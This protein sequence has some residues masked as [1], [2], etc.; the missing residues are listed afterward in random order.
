MKANKFFMTAASIMMSALVATSF[1]ACSEDEDPL[2]DIDNDKVAE[3]VDFSNLT[4]T[5]TEEGKIII[6]GELKTNTKL[7]TFTLV[8]TT[9]L[10]EKGN[11]IEY[12]LLENV[13]DNNRSE[14]DRSDWICKIPATTVP[15]D[16]YRLDV[17]ARMGKT[18]SAQIGEEFSFK[19]ATGD[20]KSVG[21][22]LSF[23]KLKSYM[24]DELKA[25]ADTCA[26]VEVIINSDRTLKP[27]TE[28]NSKDVNTNCAKAK[29]FKNVA[30]PTTGVV[31]TSTG[32]V[33]TYSSELDATDNTLVTVSGIV[34]TSNGIIKVTTGVE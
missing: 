8:S 32:C 3:K 29:V 22:Y 24:L 12:N 4:V 16:I 30:D 27:A 33:A 21:S 14:E 31:L 13:E 15:V 11:P 25:S 2:A 23:C 6:A 26:N 20:N 1:T 34:I 18:A 17:R 28:A 9:L 7:K 10:D 19:A 5:G